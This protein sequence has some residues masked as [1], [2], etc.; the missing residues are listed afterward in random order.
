MFRPACWRTCTCGAHAAEVCGLYVEDLDPRLDDKHV[1]IHGKG[2]TVRIVL[3]D[4]RSHVA[5]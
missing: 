1:H 5:P 3:R 4:D 2:A